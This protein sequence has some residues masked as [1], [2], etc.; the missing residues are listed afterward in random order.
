MTRPRMCT[1]RNLR[2]EKSWWVEK[3][4]F[5]NPA[6]TWSVCWRRIRRATIREKNPHGNSCHSTSD[7]VFCALDGGS[8]MYAD[9]TSFLLL[10][11]IASVASP[12]LPAA[13]HKGYASEDEAQQRICAAWVSSDSNR[14]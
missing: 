2:L 12:R 4:A 3:S 13:F 9:R 11:A 1:A 6:A 10:A 14:R 5:R 7:P 8:S